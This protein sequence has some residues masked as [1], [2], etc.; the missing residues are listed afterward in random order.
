MS[1]GILSPHGTLTA[2]A[3]RSR[4][5]SAVSECASCRM[6]SVKFIECGRD[7]LSRLPGATGPRLGTDGFQPRF[8]DQWGALLQAYDPAGRQS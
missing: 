7:A 3:R 8:V 6:P 2:L 5:P 1:Y 4:L